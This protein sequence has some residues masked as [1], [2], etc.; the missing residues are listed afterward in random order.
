MGQEGAQKEE[1]KARESRK[2]EGLAPI[3]N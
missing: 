3:K 2:G 1:E